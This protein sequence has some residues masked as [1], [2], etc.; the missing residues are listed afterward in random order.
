MGIGTSTRHH[1]A[2]TLKFCGRQ[3]K[4]RYKEITQEQVCDYVA[5]SVKA[6]PHQRGDKYKEPVCKKR[7]LQVDIDLSDTDQ[8]L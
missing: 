4:P 8:E 1:R 3:V 5:R 7:I 2:Y 6:S